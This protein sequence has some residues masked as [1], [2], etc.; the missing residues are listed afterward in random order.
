MLV[1]Y[2]I[3]IITN[4]NST[5]KNTEKALVYGS[6]N[7]GRQL[8]RAIQDSSDIKI[9]GFIDDDKN[10]QGCFID[11][12]EIF[13]PERLGKVIAEKE[14]NLI[15]LAIPSITRKRRHQILKELTKYKIA[16]RTIPGISEIAKGKNSITDLLDLDMDDLLGR[17]VVEPFEKLMSK[18][19]SSK[20]ILVTGCGGSIGSELCRQII[21]LDPTNILL[22]DNSEYG[23][24]RIHT[25]L[26][27]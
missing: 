3:L 16:I 25:E 23:L 21:K 6:G 13:A 27:N 20:T 15:L 17:L 9:K 4:Q 5:K 11:G 24:Y 19:I 2:L 7:A 26:E 1:R 10:Q 14:I 12:K 22:V 18:N 8:V